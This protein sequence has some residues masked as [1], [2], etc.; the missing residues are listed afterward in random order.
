MHIVLKGFEQKR[1]TTADAFFTND[2]YLC[3]LSDVNIKRQSIEAFTLTFFKKNFNPI[4]PDLI[5]HI[6]RSSNHL[7]KT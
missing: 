1:S 5:T 7:Q 3:A 6:E 2:K 4:R